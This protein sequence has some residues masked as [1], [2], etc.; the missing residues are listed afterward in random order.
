MSGKLLPVRH[1][2][3]LLKPQLGGALLFALL[4][5]KVSDTALSILLART[6]LLHPSLHLQ[7][8]MRVNSLFVTCVGATLAQLTSLPWPTSTIPWRCKQCPSLLAPQRAR[9]TGM[10]MCMRLQELLSLPQ[11]VKPVQVACL[12]A[13]IL[14]DGLGQD[15]PAASIGCLPSCIAWL[16]LSQ[17]AAPHQLI[18]PLLRMTGSQSVR[19]QLGLCCQ[20]AICFGQM[21]N[22]R[23]WRSAGLSRL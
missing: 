8:S 3:A 21:Y 14:L 18:M 13:E 10:C 6:E 11:Y 7:E 17:I 23:C 20:P 4:H 12:P 2:A 16:R 1:R 22:C 9:P 5:R 15:L 19:T